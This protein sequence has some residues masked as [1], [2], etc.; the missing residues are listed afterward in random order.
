MRRVKYGDVIGQIT[1][2]FVCAQSE[3]PGYSLH[4]RLA[5]FHGLMIEGKHGAV[6]G[7]KTHYSVCAQ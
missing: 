6:I 3:F 2:Y 7:R 1:H 5:K 4:C